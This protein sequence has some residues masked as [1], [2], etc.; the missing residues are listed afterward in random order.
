MARTKRGTPPSYRRHSSGQACVTVRCPDG[1]RR[2][3]L[4]GPWE[5]QESKAEYAR[6]LAELAINQGWL[7]HSQGGALGGMSINEVILAYW[8]HAETYYR[9]PDGTP[10]SEAD[11]I[12]LALRPLKRLYGHTLAADFDSLGLEAVRDEMIRGGRCRSRVNRDISRVRRLFRWSASKQLVP[13]SVHQSL[14]TVEGHHARLLG[15]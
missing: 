3:I 1:R 13:L 12:R 15:R 4:L 5:S 7:P 6:V 14:V 2:E 10:T 9:H 8:N 11:N